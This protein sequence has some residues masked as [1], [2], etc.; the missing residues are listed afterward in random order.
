MIHRLQLETW[1]FIQSYY[2][3]LIKL[4]LIITAIQISVDYFCISKIFEFIFI[5]NYPN[6]SMQEIFNYLSINQRHTLIQACIINNIFKIFINAILCVSILTML[7]LITNNTICRFDLFDLVKPSILFFPKLLLLIFYNTLFIQ[8]GLL[9]VLIPGIIIAILTSLSMIILIHENT[10]VIES[11]YK[12]IK[13]S[14]FN[15]NLIAPI[16]L[17]WFLIKTIVAMIWIQYINEWSIV[18]KIC[19]NSIIHL[20]SIIVLIYLYRLYILLKKNKIIY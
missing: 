4:I 20:M 10:S 19:L 7:K 18:L 9:L 2:V 15:I 16:I 5:N 1:N 8:L 11:I 17:L 13:I 6:I 14:F 3:D 12:S